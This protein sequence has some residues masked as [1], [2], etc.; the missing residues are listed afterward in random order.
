MSGLFRFP[1]SVQQV[2][3]SMDTVCDYR[4][5]FGRLLKYSSGKQRGF[6]YP[7]LLNYISMSEI[8]QVDRGIIFGKT[9]AKTDKKET[10]YMLD[11]FLAI[12]S[13]RRGP[14]VHPGEGPGARVRHSQA[15]VLAHLPEGGRAHLRPGGQLHIH[16]GHQVEEVVLRRHDWDHW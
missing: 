3:I 16:R 7:F 11:H 13:I 6:Y 14:Q 9:T 10:T 4:N 8:S 12:S 1:Y 5:P 15:G 2:P